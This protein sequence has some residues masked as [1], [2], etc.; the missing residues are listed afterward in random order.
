M[1]QAKNDDLLIKKHQ[2]ESLIR[3]TNSVLKDL[4]DLRL[5]IREELNSLTELKKKYP[6]SE[7][8]PERVHQNNQSLER[9]AV[10]IQETQEQL[11]SYHQQQDAIDAALD[12][13]RK[14]QSGRHSF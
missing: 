9:I 2:W 12:S 5:Q 10:M 11:K 6:E 4:H 3:Q 1:P 13:S 14:P 7:R 8:I